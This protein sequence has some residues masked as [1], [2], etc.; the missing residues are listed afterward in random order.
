MAASGLIGTIIKRI[1]LADLRAGY[2]QLSRNLVSRAATPRQDAHHQGP[3]KKLVLQHVASTRLSSE[4]GLE[5]GSQTQK[6]LRN[7]S[8][9]HLS[10]LKQHEKAKF[11]E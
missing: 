11:G 2:S 4:L 3:T 10:P 8:L 1:G 9:Y 5:K 6:Q 7:H